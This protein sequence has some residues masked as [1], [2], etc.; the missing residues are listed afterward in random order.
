MIKNPKIRKF[1]MLDKRRKRTTFGRIFAKAAVAALAVAAVFAYFSFYFIE[2]YIDESAD[3]EIA[4][5][6]SNIMQTM[7][8]YSRNGNPNA[9]DAALPPDT[10]FLLG[11]PV[12]YVDSYNLIGGDSNSAAISVLLDKD[13][14]EIASSRRRFMAAISFEKN[15]KDEKHPENG[16]YVCKEEEFDIPELKE[17]YDK[18]FYMNHFMTLSEDEDSDKYV[19]FILRSAYVNKAEHLFIPHE[20]N[21]EYTK[22]IT[23]KSALTETEGYK[24]EEF[25]INADIDGYEL[26]QLHSYAAGE[27]RIYPIVMLQNFHET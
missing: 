15:E 26:V 24:T 8:I 13:G 21:A 23:P 4:R 1:L 18:F 6:H 12:F 10:Y 9:A 25:T 11:A 2:M 14:N 27:S 7:N 16:W 5:T 17:F 3:R 22:A 20:V 19:N